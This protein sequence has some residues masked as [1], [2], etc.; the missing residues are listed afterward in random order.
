VYVLLDGN[1]NHNNTLS[2]DMVKPGFTR[3]SL[4]VSARLTHFTVREERGIAIL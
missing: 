3:A 1:V 2:A 4:N